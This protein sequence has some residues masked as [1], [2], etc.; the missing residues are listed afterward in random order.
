LPDTLLRQELKKKFIQELTPSEKI[1]FLKK[2]QESILLKGYQACEDLFH[3][4]YFLSLEERFRSIS[5]FKGE[6]EGY[7]RFLLVEGTK[8]I[9]NAVTLYEEKLEKKKLSTPDV[10]SYQFIEFLSE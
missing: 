5:P 6:G 9:E 1:F 4:C 8:D 10:K 7:L 3:Y 2:A